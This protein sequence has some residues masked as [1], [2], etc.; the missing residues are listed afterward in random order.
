MTL[1]AGDILLTGVPENAP[2]AKVGD[3]VRIEI[4]RIGVLENFLVHE[5]DWKWGGRA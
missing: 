4:D 1:R 3:V 5:K 2:L